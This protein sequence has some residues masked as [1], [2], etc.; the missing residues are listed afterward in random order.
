MI[1]NNRKYEWSILIAVLLLCTYGLVAIYSATHGELSSQSEH[2]FFIKQMV[3]IGIGLFM[4][5]VVS[6]LPSNWLS[7][8]APFLYGVLLLILMGLLVLGRGGGPNRWI[9]FGGLQLQPSE[10]MKPVLVMTLAAYFSSGFSLNRK[11]D[12]LLVF[13]MILVPFA[14][15]LKQPDLGTAL[16][17]L[18]IIVPMLYWRGVSLFVLFVIC[19]PI[20]TFIASFQFW[21]FFVTILVIC[22]ILIVSRRGA[23]TFWTV[24][25]F[26]IIV[27]IAAPSFWNHLHEYQQKRVLNFL[28][29]VSD[30]QGSGYQ[31]IQ[32]KVAI[33]SGGFWGKGFMEG[34]QTQLSFLPEQHTDFI[35]SVIAEEWGF[36]GS[37]VL[38]ATFIFLISR[39]IHIAS[40][41]KSDFEGLLTIGLVS[42][43]MFQI[44]V[45][46]G[47]TMG[48]MPVTGMTLP[49]I[50]YGGS[51]MMSSMV[52][53]G[54]FMNTALNRFK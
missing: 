4:F 25:F 14:L 10:F 54:L 43:F 18:V 35:F 47:M 48:I 3:W 13:I 51:S 17:F 50:S 15:V 40:T 26:N 52:M 21:S 49:F 8:S 46:M 23:L 28:G 30:P 36:V 19:A 27:G 11:M 44:L 42:M 39:G 1:L 9:G 29:I 24:F 20:V 38:I 16:T 34:S 31:I 33:G 12:I 37:M 53:A 2:L 5:F 45:N 41:A 6:M 22:T 7:M 32:S